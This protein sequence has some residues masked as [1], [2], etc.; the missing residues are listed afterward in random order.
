MNPERR[1][2]GTANR[3]FPAGASDHLGHPV[4]A[5]VNGFEPFEKGH[6]RAAPRR[7]Q[8]SPQNSLALA[9]FRHKSLGLQTS[10]S[11]LANQQN[12]APHIAQI[13][14]VE[15]KHFRAPVKARQ[16]RGE[17]VGRSGA[18]MTQVLGDD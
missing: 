17:I 5:D 13:P 9:D 4:A 1:L 12:V 3:I 18:N 7:I 10:A 11:C 2:S 14:G 16:G 6:A 8:L 15:S